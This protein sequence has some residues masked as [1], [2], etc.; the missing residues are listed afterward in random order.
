MTILALLVQPSDAGQ[1]T[2][3]AT[4]FGVDWPHLTAQIVSFAIVCA[5]LYRLA[6]TPVLR[7]LDL[8]RQQIAHGQANQERIERA[9]A[10]IDAQRRETLAAAR[11]EGAQ[12]L[13]DAREA[14]R[15]MQEQETQRAIAAANDIVA[16]ARDATAAEHARMLAELRREVGR[17]VLQTTSVVIGKVLTPDDQRVLAEDTARYLKDPAAAE[18]ARPPQGR[19]RSAPT[20]S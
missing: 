10:E 16:K 11:A 9:L 5:L 18:L 2:S 1:V 8:R 19:P 17:L 20:V 15:R 3:I 14:A 7:M 6:Y 12:L 13:A 4:T